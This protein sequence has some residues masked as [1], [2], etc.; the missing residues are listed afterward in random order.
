MGPVPCQYICCPYSI[1]ALHLE[2]QHPL[3]THASVLKPLLYR[4]EPPPPA[5]NPCQVLVLLRKSISPMLP[6]TQI[7]R[8]K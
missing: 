2:G 3:K 7:R 1:R 5:E 8:K 6:I 4:T